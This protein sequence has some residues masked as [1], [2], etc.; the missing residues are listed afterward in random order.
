MKKVYLMKGMA[1]MALGLV[2]ASCNKTDVFNPYA[3]QEAKQQE[4]TANFQKSVMDG[5]TIDPNQTWST[6][7]MANITV[8]LNLDYGETYDVLVFT[9]DPV[10][11]KN[12]SFIGKTQMKSGESKTISVARPSDV[13]NLYV[14]VYDKTGYMMTMPVYVKDNAASANFGTT[15][16]QNVARRTATTGNSY[17]VTAYSAPDLSEYNQGTTITDEVN[18][19]TNIPATANYFKIDQDWTGVFAPIAAASTSID[20]PMSIYVTAKWTINGDQRINGGCIVIVGDGGEIVINEGANL[21]TNDDHNYSGM[22][23]VLPGG[24]ITGKGLLAFHNATEGLK[25]TYSYNGGTINVGT[26]NLNGGTL[27]NANGATVQATDIQGGAA[28][29]KLIN[30]GKAVFT[31]AGDINNMGNSAYAGLQWENAC[32]LIVTN[33]LTIANNSKLDQGGYIECGNL[34]LNGAD[35]T[36]GTRIYMGPSSFINIAGD[37]KTNNLGI[38][39]PTTGEY[40]F[41]QFKTNSFG[42]YGNNKNTYFYGHLQFVYPAGATIQNRFKEAWACNAVNQSW[43]YTN[44]SEEEAKVLTSNTTK[45]KIE[46]SDCSKGTTGPGTE[47]IPSTPSYIYFAFEDLGTTD[48]FD[49]NDVVIRVSTPVEGISTVELCAAGGTMPTYVLYDGAILGNGEEVHAKFG[50]S[51]STM[52]NTLGAEGSTTDDEFKTLGTIN[53]AGTADLT[54]LPFSISVNNNNGQST[55]VSVGNFNGKAPLYITASGDENGRWFW[56]TGRTN[57]ADAF[58]TFADWAADATSNTD[59]YKNATSGKVFVWE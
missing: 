43:G 13:H 17:S 30:Q 1:A 21:S 58:E 50:V 35:A 37:I 3:E 38:E 16:A 40:A 19:N 57:I 46:A 8:N 9:A 49:F 28:N 24:K 55:L 39:A 18:S 11:N 51:T 47:I 2:V 33:T 23:Y 56:P 10:A 6:S 25:T 53:V 14:A 59:W 29:S 20:H 42:N 32:Q 5:K 52:V 15:S 48:D 7:T 4:F 54:T 41:V 45:D 27:Y 44:F 36:D 22:I 26:I 34:V 31:N 12:I